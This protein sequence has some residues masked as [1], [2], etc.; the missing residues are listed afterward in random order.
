MKSRRAFLRSH[1]GAIVTLYWSGD[2]L[3]G[4]GG[5]ARLFDVSLNRIQSLRW[6]IGLFIVW[7]LATKRHGLLPWFTQ[8][9]RG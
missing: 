9:R 2:A 3:V 5:R 7:L 8:R 4:A 6:Q 1:L